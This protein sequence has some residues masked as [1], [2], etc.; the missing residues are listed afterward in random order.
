MSHVR[1]ILYTLLGFLAACLPFGLIYLS[2]VALGTMFE[3]DPD[4]TVPTAGEITLLAQDVNIVVGGVSLTLPLIAL[5]DQSQR[6][7]FFSDNGRAWIADRA[8]DRADFAASASALPLDK[9]RV[10]IEPFGLEDTI[11]VRWREICDQL[12]HDWARSVCADPRAPLMQAL[13]RGSLHL[14]D[15]RHLDAFRDTYLSIGDLGEAAP[16]LKAMDLEAGEPALACGQPFK[17]DAPRPCL[18]A[19]R[20]TGD[21]VAVWF[22]ADG[23]DEIA[24]AQ[25]LREGRAITALVVHGLGPVEDFPSLT[26]T[27]CATLRPGAAPFRSDDPTWPC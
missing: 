8:A 9:V 10:Y 24:E 15:A 25:A 20:I 2:G 14:A 12:T 17:P 7:A 4:I 5:P 18:V 22:V 19:Q 13:P 26:A 23:P 3:S 27:A 16:I 11:G 6:D 1:P 21:L